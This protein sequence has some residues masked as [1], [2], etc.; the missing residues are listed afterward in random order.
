VDNVNQQVYEYV[1]KVAKVATPI[2]KP[3]PAGKGEVGDILKAS[4]ETIRYGESSID[5]VTQDFV[6]QSKDILTK[7]AK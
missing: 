3:D 1:D 5:K 2:D 7:A 6:A 4:V